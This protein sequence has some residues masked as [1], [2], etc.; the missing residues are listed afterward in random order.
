MIKIRNLSKTYTDSIVET[1]ALKGIDLD[2]DE[3]EF[4]A[5]IGKLSLIHI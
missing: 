4:V 1:Q 5:I 2:I 3:G